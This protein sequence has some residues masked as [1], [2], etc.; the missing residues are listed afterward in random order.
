MTGEDDL[1]SLSLMSASLKNAIDAC[2]YAIQHAYRIE[3]PITEVYVAQS[4]LEGHKKRVE[5]EL[6]R[7]RGE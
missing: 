1:A 3:W 6:A 4:I 5:A 2:T 7:R